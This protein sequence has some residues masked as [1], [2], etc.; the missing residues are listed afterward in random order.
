MELHARALTIFEREAPLSVAHSVVLNNAGNVAKVTGDLRQAEMLHRRALDIRQKLA[1]GSVEV[2]DSLYNLGGV[3][4]ARGD[5]R[6]AERYYTDAWSIVEQRAPDSLEAAETLREARSAR[7]KCGAYQT[8]RSP[9]TCARWMRS[10]P[11]L[12]AWAARMTCAPLSGRNTPITTAIPSSCSCNARTPLA[13][14]ACSSVRAPDRCS[15]CW[16]NEIS[17]CQRTCPLTWR[18][19]GAIST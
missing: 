7:P 16:P 1:P 9:T 12:G 13:R 15:P 6:E 3:A 18:A 14:F 5:R 11:T 8:R 19:R 10:R 17:C 2:A 4:L